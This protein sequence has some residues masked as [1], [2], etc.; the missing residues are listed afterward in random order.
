MAQWQIT[1][2]NVADPTWF[3][4][5]LWMGPGE[6]GFTTEHVTAEMKSRG[7]D[8]FNHIGRSAI[9]SERAEPEVALRVEALAADMTAKAV[10]E[11]QAEIAATIPK[12][13]TRPLTTA[14]LAQVQDEAVQQVE[15]QS[16]EIDAVARAVVLKDMGLAEA[17]SVSVETPPISAELQATL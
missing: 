14:E 7:A 15:S 10:E 8:G 16:A 2:N 4:D 9:L 6:D 1:K 13:E 11:K 17:P 5:G 3:D 12:D